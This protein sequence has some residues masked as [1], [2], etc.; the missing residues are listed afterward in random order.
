MKDLEKVSLVL[1]AAGIIALFFVTE[2]SKPAEITGL[3]VDS[4]YIGRDVMINGTIK[5]IAIREGNV[6]AT[7]ENS[8]RVVLFRG[9]AAG[10]EALRRGDKVSVTGKVQLYKNQL[11]IV[12]EEIKKVE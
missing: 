12:A 11:E 8:T 7:L 6:F 10:S 9:K 3:A 4:S 5:S 1:A 2:S